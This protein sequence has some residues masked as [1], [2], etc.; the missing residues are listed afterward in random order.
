M[1][2]VDLIESDLKRS[3][4]ACDACVCCCHFCFGRPVLSCLVL[5]RI[6]SIWLK[7]PPAQPNTHS[8]SLSLSGRPTSQTSCVWCEREQIGQD[9]RRFC[10][11]WLHLSFWVSVLAPHS[12]IHT[13][14]H[15]PPSSMA[16]ER[17]PHDNTIDAAHGKHRPHA[18]LWLSCVL[19]GLLARPEN[20]A[21][22][23]PL[24]RPMVNI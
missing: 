16:C 12:Y 2:Q 17:R 5:F 19:V 23:Q 8:L 18:Q 3:R 15:L 21:P 4:L 1:L 13:T 6:T 7:W 24:V 14:C 22:Q 9:S 10:S 20:G 11:S